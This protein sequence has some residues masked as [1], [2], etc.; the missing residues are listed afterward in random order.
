MTRTKPDPEGYLVALDRLGAGVEPAA[1][2]VFEDT[3]LGVTAA[4]AAGMRCAAVLGS[5]PRER[6]AHADE[7][8]ERL[9]AV[10]VLRLLA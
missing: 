3:P 5:A 7:I 9:D 1:V 2:L 10:T 8:V 6:L 4:K